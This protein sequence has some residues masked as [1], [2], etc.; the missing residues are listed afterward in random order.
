MP[1]RPDPPV[2]ILA[3]RSPRRTWLLREA[4]YRFTQADPPFDDPAQPT[5]AV[6]QAVEDLAGQLSKQKASSLRGDLPAHAVILAA[7]TICI[8][9][10]NQPIGQP[11][12]REDAR[13][14]IRQFIQNTHRVVTGVALLVDGQDEPVTLTD[15]AT[16]T[17]GSLSGVQLEDYL[18][19]KEWM[20]KAGGY[21]LFDRRAEGWPL[22][23]EGDET[24]VVGLP[25]Q[26]LVPVLKTLGVLPEP[27]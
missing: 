23:V 5:I 11:K 8:G 20:G 19:T 27:R 24:T 13:R 21:N 18:D 9:Q 26:K 12:D 16:V 2:L 25:M 10:D 4:G 15:L 3:S 22:T 6:G 17:L 14:M 7:D 1:D